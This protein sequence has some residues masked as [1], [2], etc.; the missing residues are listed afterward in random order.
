MP[1]DRKQCNKCKYLYVG[2]GA[3]GKSLDHCLAIENKFTINKELYD[4]MEAYWRKR[5]RHDQV[6]ETSCPG[7]NAEAL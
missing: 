2:G 1:D 3:F 5:L 4:E 7:F 6:M